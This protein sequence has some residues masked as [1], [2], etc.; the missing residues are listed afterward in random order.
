M[1]VQLEA[2][3]PCR[4]EK[5]TSLSGSKDPTRQQMEPTLQKGHED[6]IAGKGDNSMNHFYLVH[7]FIPMQKAI[8][9]RDANAAVEKE[10]K[11]LETIQAWKL[12]KV[13]NMQEVVLEAR[14]NKSKVHFAALMDLCDLKNVEFRTET[15]ESTKVESCSEVT[16]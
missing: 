6:H 1:E 2:A 15:P 11:K 8:K 12:D 3:M 9:I 16:L 10:W 4:K 13:E 14:R 5:P 7:E